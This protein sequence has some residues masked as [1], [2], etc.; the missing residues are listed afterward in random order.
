MSCGCSK[1]RGGL[2]GSLL[3][4]ERTSVAPEEWGPVM[5]KFLHCSA[6]RIGR[7][8]SP[9]V[10]ADEGRHMELLV[11]H[12]PEVLPCRECQAHAREYILANRPTG[13]SGLRGD[14]LRSAVV[15]WLETFHNTVRV[16]QG[17][18]I[19]VGESYEG[20][21]VA[22]CEYKIIVDSIVYATTLGWVKKDAWKRWQRTMGELRL[23]IGI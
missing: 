9:L 5:W 6:W 3:I 15:G 7:T 22:T 19:V 21:S 20:C 16:R 10:D 2:S 13:W 8:G 4:G 18:E 1:K 12:L 23:L 14:A 11:G 17:K